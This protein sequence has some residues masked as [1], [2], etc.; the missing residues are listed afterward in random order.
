MLTWIRVHA[1]TGA[2]TVLGHFK[3]LQIQVMGE[4]QFG[5]AVW[6]LFKTLDNS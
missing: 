6:A 5:M 4:N 3:T 2:A 1:A